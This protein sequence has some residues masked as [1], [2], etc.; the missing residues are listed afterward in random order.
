MNSV[1]DRMTPFRLVPG[2]V[3]TPPWTYGVRMLSSRSFAAFSPA[4]TKRGPVSVHWVSMHVL[5]SGSRRASFVVATAST[6]SGPEVVTHVSKSE[7]SLRSSTPRR[8]WVTAQRPRPEET[9]LPSSGRHPASTP[10]RSATSSGPGSSSRR[11]AVNAVPAGSI[12]LERKARSRAAPRCRSMAVV[13]R[14]LTWFGSGTLV[15]SR[16]PRTQ[17]RLARAATAWSLPVPPTNPSHSLTDAGP[18]TSSTRARRAPAS[19]VPGIWGSPWRPG[20]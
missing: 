15:A 2:T 5:G 17:R 10:H 16:E 13:Q 18:R 6:R 20:R 12:S 9:P 14:T 3:S 8:S 11:Y 1:R 4:P 7:G 19:D